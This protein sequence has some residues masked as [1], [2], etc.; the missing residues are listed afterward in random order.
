MKATLAFTAAVF[1]ML[2]VCSEA[3]SVLPL[4]FA[5]DFDSGVTVGSAATNTFQTGGGSPGASSRVEIGTGSGNFVLQQRPNGS[6]TSAAVSAAG[7]AGNAFTIT[8]TFDI[9]NYTNTG[10]IA[11]NMAIGFLGTNVNLSTGDR[12]YL[13]YS[14][15][16]GNF[17]ITKNGGGTAGTFTAGAASASYA[18]NIGATFS[19]TLNGTYESNGT[20]NIVG[21]ITNGTDTFQVTGRDTAPVAGEYFG[22]RAGTTSGATAQIN[23]QEFSLIPE[24]SAAALVALAGVAVGFRRRRA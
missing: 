23:Y 9:G 16:N 11:A 21:I 18:A 4:P 10:T 17:S 5:T 13:A 6:N 2:S 14:L 8:T 20:L 1:A 3:A 12:Y 19:L 15:T 7:V 24:P 22:L